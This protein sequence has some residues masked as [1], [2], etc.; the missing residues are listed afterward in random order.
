[1]MKLA[2]TIALIAL[3]NVGLNAQTNNTDSLKTDSVEVVIT[4]KKGQDSTIVKVAGMKIIVLSNERNEPKKIVVDTEVKDDTTYYT[5]NQGDNVS[6]WA[7]VRIGVNGFLSNEGL[8]LPASHRFLE[9]DYGKSVCV[10]VNLLEKD[11][12][13]YK[14]HIELVTGLGMHF[15]NYTF[16][17]KYTTLLN[18]DPLSASVDSTILLDKNKLRAT[19]LTAPLMLGFSTH[20]DESKAFRFAAGGQVSWRIAS[21]LKQQYN[22]GGQ[23]FKPRIKSDYDLNPLLFHAIAS[24]GYGPINLVAT[25]GLNTLFES[26]KTVALNPFDVGVQ[27][28]F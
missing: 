25:Y 23:T 26:N 22:F 7:G 20:K 28:M 3:T 8:P 11:F 15:A 16:K 18:T 14:Q 21:K 10:D 6:H 19:Y 2:L 17:N 12:R 9:L 1:M 5:D 4:P 24:M 13:L 27:I